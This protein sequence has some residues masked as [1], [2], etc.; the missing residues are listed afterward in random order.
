VLERLTADPSDPL[1]VHDGL[2]DGVSGISRI[3]QHATV[4]ITLPLPDDVT[5]KN[6]PAATHITFNRGTPTTLNTPALD[7][8]LMY[9]LRD[10]SLQGQALGAIHGHAQNTREPTELELDLIAEFQ[11]TKRFFSNGKLRRFAEGGSAPELPLGTTESEQRGRLFFVDAPFAPPSKVGVCALCH[12]GPM[13][14][15]ANIFSTP[16]FGNPPG[17]RIHNVLVS[18]RNVLGNP[19]YTF[20]LYDTLDPEPVEVT[21]PD[22]G[23][24]MTD[25]D[26][27]LAEGFIPPDMVLGP[28]FGIRRGF[29]A[30]F[31]KTPTLWGVK[32]TAPYFHD[33]SAKNLDEMLEQYDFF[34]VNSQ[35][36]GAIQLT[37]QDKEDIKAFLQ[38]L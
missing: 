19:T 13:L 4:R 10:V 22:L 25:H 17:A 31:F 37:A 16:V 15:A 28:V 7:D 32:D 29:F 11:Q 33:N 8:L 38:L 9:D 36:A 30:S 2:D 35:I 34:F 27:L 24:L 12:S 1:F 5:L 14:N 6:D 21:T 20:E 23:F 26:L 3:L 18:E